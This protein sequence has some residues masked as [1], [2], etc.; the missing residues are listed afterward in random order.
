VQWTIRNPALKQNKKKTVMFKNIL[1]KS[2]LLYYDDSPQ[3]MVLVCPES[4][5]CKLA[6]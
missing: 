5:N 6:Y 1:V 3:E 2:L 4:N